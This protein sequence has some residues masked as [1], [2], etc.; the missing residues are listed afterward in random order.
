M[1]IPADHGPVISRQV[2]MK[3]TNLADKPIDLS[4]PVCITPIDN[5]VF[6]H[7]VL[8][9]HDGATWQ[10]T[11]L[12]IPFDRDHTSE[13]VGQWR[14]DCLSVGRQAKCMVTEA[15]LGMFGDF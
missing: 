15:G 12:A 7:L 5:H 14:V 3:A 8:T 11:R 4:G 13:T 1:R 10:S 6:T 9:P 2:L